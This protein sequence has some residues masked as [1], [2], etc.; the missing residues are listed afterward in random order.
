L[1]KVLSVENL[2]HPEFRG[3]LFIDED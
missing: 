2:M 3:Q 1:N